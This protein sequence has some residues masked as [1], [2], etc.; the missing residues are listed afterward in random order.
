MS[1]TLTL[2]PPLEGEYRDLVKH[3][4][5]DLKTRMHVEVHLTREELDRLVSNLKGLTLMEAEKILTKA[6]VEDNMLSVADI[7]R[8]VEGKRAVIEREGLL[9]YY[10]A[11]A[12]MT[13]LVGLSGLKKLAGK[14]PRH[15]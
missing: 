6:M 4:Y 3:I 11:E 13:E 2:P 7:R 14:A 9:E 8:V 10:P 12:D 5:R 15:H 1:A